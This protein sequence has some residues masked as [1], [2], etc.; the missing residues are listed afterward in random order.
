MRRAG[1]MPLSKR[2][3]RW[4][5]ALGL[6]VALV[7]GGL[8]LIGWLMAR[9]TPVWWRSLN[10]D[11][12]Q[13]RALGETIENAL[14]NELHKADRPG[15]RSG[16][17][18]RS[19]D[20]GFFVAAGDANAWLSTRLDA[21]LENRLEGFDFPDEITEVQAEFNDGFVRLGAR[22]TRGDSRTVISA[23]LRPEIRADGSLWL[24]V[25]GVHI[26]RLPVPVGWVLGEGRLKSFAG[27]DADLEELLRAFAGR[28]PLMREPVIELGDG[29][30]VRLLT[31][32]AT[33]GRLEVTCR[34][35]FERE[36]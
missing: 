25:D 20:W 31:L 15:E 32:A 11:D 12:P 9:Q 21:W 30:R 14:V 19:E 17:A 6:A 7:G 27:E 10:P 13:V 8:V 35:E 1:R 29:R 26:G 16:A 28:S 24:A 2:F 18:W 36:E 23:R 5:L 33:R 34:T 3:R 4:L 22:V